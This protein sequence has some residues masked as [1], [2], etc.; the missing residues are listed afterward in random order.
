[1][2]QEYYSLPMLT[3]ALMFR[4]EHPK[5]TLQQ[6]VAQQLHLLLTTGLGECAVNETFGCNIW[7][8]DFNNQTSGHKLKE[9]IKQSLV[10][11]IQ[12]HEKRLS[13]IKVDVQ[14]SQNEVTEKAGSSRIR[15][16]MDFTIA[17]TLHMT[18]EKFIYKDNFFIGPL[19]Y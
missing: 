18:N 1:M 13:M 12:A 15:K 7:D 17:G 19:S 16:R 14:V 9:I 10:L 11:T 4:K 8:Y 6:S 5:C 3:D 2:Q